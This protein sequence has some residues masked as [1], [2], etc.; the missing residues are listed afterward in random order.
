MKCGDLSVVTDILHLERLSLSYAEHEDRVQCSA[1]DA[2]G[3]SVKLW[4]TARLLN[5]LVPHLVRHRVASGNEPAIL[6]SPTNSTAADGSEL[7]PVI[8][9]PGCIEVLVA[10]IELQFQDE[11]VCLMF[12]EAG[13]CERASLALSGTQ[14]QT[15]NRGLQHC[16]ES[17]GWPLEPFSTNAG[18]NANSSYETATIH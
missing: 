2:E 17:A 5:R 1:L 18:N 6:A 13:R 16:F 15:F 7:A 8:C 9:E 3:S 4:L 12:K 11:G 10:E 14:L